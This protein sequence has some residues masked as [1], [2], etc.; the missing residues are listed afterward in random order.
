[1]EGVSSMLPQR[2]GPVF[3]SLLVIFGL[4]LLL[5]WFVFH[6][7]AGTFQ[8]GLEHGELITPARKID[9]PLMHNLQGNVVPADLFRG[10]W[11][12]LYRVPDQAGVTGRGVTNPCDKDCLALMDTLRRVRIAQDRS[13]RE[14]QRVLSLPESAE[15]VPGIANQ[16]DKELDVVTAADWPLQAGSVYVIDPQGFLVLRY[17]PGFDP[18]G[19]LKDLKRLLRLAGK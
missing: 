11:T 2:K 4:P 17:P 18:T 10:K 13:M 12:L 14:V 3:V 9:A 15:R 19:L 7:Y 6:Y 16:F 8:G 1:M 5:A